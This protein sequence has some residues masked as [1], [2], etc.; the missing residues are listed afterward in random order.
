MRD[1]EMI[2]PAVPERFVHRKVETEFIM[3]RVLAVRV[4]ELTFSLSQRAY[5][6]QSSPPVCTSWAASPCNHRNWTAALKRDM[7][8]VID[9]NSSQTLK[10]HNLLKGS[11]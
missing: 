9:A 7:E 5:S 2:T 1:R 4:L 6:L 8:E 10:Q 3:M 11:S